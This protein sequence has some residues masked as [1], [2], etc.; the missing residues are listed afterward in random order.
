MT[1]RPTIHASAALYD[2]CG[3]LVRGASGAGKSRL[4]LDLL[5]DATARGR[6]A[7]LIADDR[8]EVTAHHGRVVARAPETIAGRVEL[9]GLG[10]VRIGH[11]TAAVVALVVDIEETQPPRMPEE[12]ARFVEIAGVLLPCLKLWREDSRGV[13][14]VRNALR[15]LAKGS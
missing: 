1:G 3:V 9:R 6:D 15:A 10:I 4:V 12:D 8:V 14:R 7:A 5:D 11:E 2:G 13:V